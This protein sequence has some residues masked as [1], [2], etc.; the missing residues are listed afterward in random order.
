MY[1]RLCHAVLLYYTIIPQHSVHYQCDKAIDVQSSKCVIYNWYKA[2]EVAPGRS[3][4][5]A[6]HGP[7]AHWCWVVA[8]ET[9]ADETVR[10]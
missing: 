9:V 3:V 6:H 4:V 7:G 5:A 10:Q 2:V 8:S 1:M